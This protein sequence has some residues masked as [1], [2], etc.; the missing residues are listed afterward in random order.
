MKTPSLCRML[1]GLVLI[2]LLSCTRSA[3]IVDEKRAAELARA[4]A[5]NHGWRDLEVQS[6]RLESNL[7]IVVVRRVPH[8]I[9]G[10]ARVEIAT[11]GEVKRFVSGR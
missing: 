6:L 11:N 1:A 7:W 4:E 8:D 10:H 2:G 9:G 3:G 5:K